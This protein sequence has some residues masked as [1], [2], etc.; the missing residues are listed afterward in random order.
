[1]SNQPRSIVELDGSESVAK[2]FLAL[3]GAL[4]EAHPEK[5]IL[6][7]QEVWKLQ[8]VFPGE[9][10]AETHAKLVALETEF[11]AV[12]QKKTEAVTK[13]L[14]MLGVQTDAGFISDI[15]RNTSAASD[16]ICLS[17]RKR[18]GLEHILKTNSWEEN[19]VTSSVS[20]ALDL[21]LRAA[22]NS[23]SESKVAAIVVGALKA[24]IEARG[25]NDPELAAIIQTLSNQEL[26]SAA[27]DKFS[28]Y[29]SL[30][31]AASS[32][33]SHFPDSETIKQNLVQALSST[34][35]ISPARS[36]ILG[37]GLL[38][39]GNLSNCD[40][41]REVRNAATSL[42]LRES[43]KNLMKEFALREY[44]STPDSEK[45]KMQEELL[46][47]GYIKSQS[48]FTELNQKNSEISYASVGRG[49]L[50]AIS[51]I[52][53]E[54]GDALLTKRAGQIHNSRI[55]LPKGVSKLKP[56]Q[57]LS[58]RG[59]FGEI[60]ERYNTR[61]TRVDSASTTRNSST[62]P[63]ADK[64]VSVS[65]AH[66]RPSSEVG[67]GV[68]S[69]VQREGNL[70]QNKEPVTFPPR[71]TIR[72][73]PLGMERPVLASP[74]EDPILSPHA[75]HHTVSGAPQ[76][77]TGRVPTPK[78][79]AEAIQAIEKLPVT[80]RA[81][82]LK[83]EMEARQTIIDQAKNSANVT[84]TGN[85]PVV[86]PATL[87]RLK[88][89]HSNLD[90]R[91]KK[92]DAERL[93]VESDVAQARFTAEDANLRSQGNGTPESLL[94]LV[95]KRDKARLIQ[96]RE[97]E[98]L[99]ANDLSENNFGDGQN[100]YG[101]ASDKYKA[102]YTVAQARVNKAQKLVANFDDEIFTRYSE[103]T[104]SKV[105][106]GIQADDSY[107]N[108][109]DKEA[110]LTSVHLSERQRLLA[111][112]RG[113][114]NTELQALDAGPT[115]QTPA[116]V[117]PNTGPRFQDVF[118]TRDQNI[119]TYRADL[120][121]LNTQLKQREDA[122]HAA[123]EIA[124]KVAV[125]KAAEE[126][127][128]NLPANPAP[129]VYRAGPVIKLLDK[130]IKS[131]STDEFHKDGLKNLEEALTKL[132]TAKTTAEADAILKDAVKKAE[133]TL[134]DEKAGYENFRLYRTAVENALKRIKVIRSSYQGSSRTDLATRDRYSALV[135]I[136]E[137]LNTEA[138]NKIKK[139]SA[140]QPP[141]K[142]TT[143]MQWPALGSLGFGLATLG[144]DSWMGWRMHSEM[145]T[146]LSEQ[147][148]EIEKATATVIGSFRGLD[149]EVQGKISAAENEAATIAKKATTATSEILREGAAARVTLLTQHDRGG[150]MML[151]RNAKELSKALEPIN[152]A[153]K[154]E[155]K[156]LEFSVISYRPG[157][158]TSKETLPLKL[159]LEAMRNPLSSR[160]LGG[161]DGMSINSLSLKTEVK[162]ESPEDTETVK[163]V[164]FSYSAPRAI[165][166]SIDLLSQLQENLN[167]C[168]SAVVASIVLQQRAVT[169]LLATK[170]QESNEI[171]DL[172]YGRLKKSDE[173]IG[174][175]LV[176]VSRLQDIA[177]ERINSPYATAAMM[178]ELAF[179]VARDFSI[180]ELQHMKTQD[181]LTEKDLKL[182]TDLPGNG[183][184]LSAK[185]ADE[186]VKEWC[187]NTNKLQKLVQTIA[188]DL[189]VES[190]LPFS[191][192]HWLDLAPTKTA[193]D[194]PSKKLPTEPPI[195]Y[196]ERGS[197]LT[198]KKVVGE[199]LVPSR[200]GL[201]VDDIR[202][203]NKNILREVVVETG[204]PAPLDGHRA[205]SADEKRVGEI[206]K[207]RATY[208]AGVGTGAYFLTYL[209]R[210][211][212]WPFYQNSVLGSWWRFGT[213][214]TT[215]LSLVAINSLDMWRIGVVREREEN[216]AAGR[217]ASTFE[218]RNKDLQTSAKALSDNYGLNKSSEIVKR[219][220][221]QQED[222]VREATSHVK[223]LAM[224]TSMQ[225]QLSQL[226]PTLRDFVDGW[227]KEEKNDVTSELTRQAKTNL[228]EALDGLQLTP[229][230]AF[231][232]LDVPA[233][234][235]SERFKG[236]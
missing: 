24:A 159:V 96:K 100:Q 189:V 68:S 188:T 147:K 181:R 233:L 82:Q 21:N 61:P 98:F 170:N 141:E 26:W 129:V 73:G 197:A 198:R 12:Q 40:S 101:I 63:Y 120:A 145:K 186:I 164:E 140:T 38:M 158:E 195:L 103:N 231:P 22:L 43:E 230:R 47:R 213:G 23:G 94:T 180:P 69:S 27:K 151:D 109:V 99:T 117:A 87:S 205:E 59:G 39:T 118:W 50:E 138:E 174:S 190:K 76:A 155:G 88:R 222:N 44:F 218:R 97:E 111:E 131:K 219:A 135:H 226:F 4:R 121:K 160:M 54:I 224:Y 192:Q 62:Q 182:L 66:A 30:V 14:S 16:L 156:Q 93:V 64:P 19:R 28:N 65:N 95:E 208:A 136:E 200:F 153:L 236:K 194:V 106:S 148:K 184:Y 81:A 125:A 92:A 152:S 172:E 48:D 144:A 83:L 49:V 115:G 127:A 72:S 166:A 199:S 209:S 114:I 31:K 225:I 112:V 124:N 227:I 104:K 119:P 71:L 207:V 32:F 42:G 90:Q 122:V 74:G 162:A 11:F 18:G 46:A 2:A 107:N 193:L 176:D 137:T 185:G 60:V 171:V 36:E 89:E 215:G 229:V 45:A 84:T 214:V 134:T 102:I 25:G 228:R 79:F 165:K 196:D 216:F 187:S 3:Q 13:A 221:I 223:A 206:F 203:K 108:R 202:D 154:E 5:S 80:Q 33:L 191:S 139:H 173:Q 77:T 34:S 211:T 210:G 143:K 41:I 37:L 10:K 234:T 183:A 110:Q 169:K 130:A 149:N 132:E 217:L 6:P 20:E 113:I 8:K 86:R 168:Q 177:R 163:M 55:P 167:E 9:F 15:E 70:S 52:G 126:T 157:V 235:P 201:E 75:N 128:I 7:M 57:E 220:N 35:S 51:T 150:K 161:I 53:R 78:N 29:R 67:T 58:F 91:F 85:A 116:H 175:R 133:S 1:M 123:L 204:K 142:K 232:F 146:F 17:L 212:W 56:N 178:Q 179:R 105:A